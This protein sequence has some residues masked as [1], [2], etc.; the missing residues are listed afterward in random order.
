MD[1]QTLVANAKALYDSFQLEEAQQLYKQA[2]SLVENESI[3]S[4]LLD[5][6]AE[7]C[8]ASGDTEAAKELYTESVKLYPTENISK[9]LWLAQMHSGREALQLYQAAIEAMRDS[10]EHKSSLATAYSAVAELY[11]T[12]L[13]DEP[14][15]EETCEQCVQDAL[16][17]DPNC[18]DAYQALANLRLVRNRV[19]EAQSA[20][21]T[22]LS[23][24]KSTENLPSLQFL[25]EVARNLIEVQ[26]FE[27]VVKVCKLGLAVDES[28]DELLYMQGF[29]LCKLERT[30]EAKEVVEVLLQRNLNPEIREATQELSSLLV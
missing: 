1:I 8:V 15:A 27:G 17:A 18:I 3:P 26:N 29:G 19:E 30:E 5:G 2:F 24:L 14:E 4:E 13:C 12:D 11:M 23:L 22:L 10:Q 16:A 21:Q 25:G 20:C 9:Y 7:L 28:N 6:Y